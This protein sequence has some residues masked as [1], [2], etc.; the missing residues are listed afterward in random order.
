[1]LQICFEIVHLESITESD[2]SVLRG[3]TDTA[4]SHGVLSNGTAYAFPLN[5]AG[6]MDGDTAYH[7]NEVIRRISIMSARYLTAIIIPH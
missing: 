4:F 2:P 5:V 6:S 7:V 3:S 1:M